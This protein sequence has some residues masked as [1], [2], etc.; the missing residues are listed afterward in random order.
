MVTV[1]KFGGSSVATP[2]QIKNIAKYL[3]LEKEKGKKI[4]VVVSAMG[5]TTDNLINLSKEITDNPNLREMDMLLSTGEQQTIALLSMAINS[6]G[7]KAIS[8]TASQVRIESVGVHTKNRIKD[9]DTK[10]LTKLLEEDNIVIV[11]GFQGINELNDITT[12]G[13]G[14]SDTTAV[15]LACKLNSKCEIFTDVTGIFGIDPRIYE[16]AKKIDSISYEEMMELSHL[17]AGVM[18]TRSIELASKY[19]IDVYVGKT[20]SNEK[21]TRITSKENIVETKIVKGISV[22]K[23]LM[24]VT[25]DNISTYAKNVYSVFKIADELSISLDMISQNDVLSENGSFAF[26]TSK[27]E[28]VSIQKMEEIL[29]K[30]KP[31]ISVNI[32]TRMSKLSLVGI[33]LISQIG[34]VS[35]IFKILSDNNIS[36]HQVATSEISISI[37]LDETIV[38]DV[39]RLLAKEFEL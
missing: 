1:K 5:K 20:L 15:A 13:R 23:N 38:D 6:L 16:N 39:A 26:T 2:E 31:E 27:T 34:I 29:K 4:V 3:V 10:Y 9:I 24:H 28:L 21:P 22:N 37:V 30:E 19:N 8:L 11:A 35:K 36:F 12:L 32:N 18:E 7:Q 17:G 33:G 14:G 25:I